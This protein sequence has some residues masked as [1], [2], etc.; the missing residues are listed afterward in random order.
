VEQVPSPRLFFAA[1]LATAQKL[2]A[3]IEGPQSDDCSYLQA[4]GVVLA[5]E[6]LRI[7]RGSTNRQGCYQRRPSRLAAARSDVLYI[8]EHLAKPVPLTKLAELAGLSTYHFCRALKQFFGVPPH[9]YHTSQRI[10]C[11]NSCRCLSAPRQS[12]R[13]GAFRHQDSPTGAARFVDCRLNGS[14]IISSSVALGTLILDIHNKSRRWRADAA[15]ACAGR[16]GQSYGAHAEHPG[17]R[18]TPCIYFAL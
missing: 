7:N 16:S 8:D 3:L 18:Q 13:L 1:L 17:A 12:H 2:M 10:E 15:F 14:G 9:R 11:A 4:L 5:H 6:L